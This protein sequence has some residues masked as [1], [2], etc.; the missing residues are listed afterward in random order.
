MLVFLLHLWGICLRVSVAGFLGYD[1]L[2]EKWVST[3]TYAVFQLL[4][5]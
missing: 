4:V 1:V 3:V 2:A 5:F